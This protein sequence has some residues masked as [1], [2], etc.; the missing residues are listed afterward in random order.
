MLSE[1]QLS[2]FG[3]RGYL[4]IPNVVE[5]DIMDRARR[6]IDDTVDADPPAEGHT[7][8]HFYFLNDEDEPALIAPLTATGTEGASSFAHAE[9]LTAPGAL[10]QLWQI[11]VALNIPPFSHRPGRPHIDAQNSEPTP[12]VVP[13]TF[14]L[15]AGVFVTDQL[16]QDSGNLWIWPGTHLTHAEYF[17]QNGVEMFCAYPDIELPEPVQVTARAGDLLLAHYLLGHNIGGN[18][19]ERTR[20]MLYYR[21]SARGH[22]D[23][24]ERILTEPWYE[25][26]AVRAQL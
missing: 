5:P 8:H 23:Q 13:N 1:K 21:I 20:R 15:L 12:G 4:V 11:Q 7:G 9:A 24:P 3:E 2:E 22:V 25:Y 18:T 26:D 19:S 10:E 16:N 14:T 6:R 17:Q